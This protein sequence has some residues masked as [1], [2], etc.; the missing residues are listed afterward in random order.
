MEMTND[1]VEL[2]GG[3]L[4]MLSSGVYATLLWDLK[5]NT[6]ITADGLY[7][8]SQGLFLMWIEHEVLIYLSGTNFGVF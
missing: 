6:I 1:S 5:W 4:W 2:S 7:K 3:Y 8:G